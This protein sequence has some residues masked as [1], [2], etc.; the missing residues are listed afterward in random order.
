MWLLW[1]RTGLPRLGRNENFQGQENVREF[2][3]KS[4]KLFDT[5]KFSEKF[6]N[7]L[8]RSNALCT[9]S[10]QKWKEVENGMTFVSLILPFTSSLFKIFESFVCTVFT[11][12]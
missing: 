10:S 3:K 11:R 2:R 1:Y 8:V 5:V 9:K 12:V 4:G 6:W 7:L